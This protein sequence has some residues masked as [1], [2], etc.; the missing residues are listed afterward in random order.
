[1]FQFQ[2]LK[3]WDKL[4]ELITFFNNTFSNW[5]I[6]WGDLIHFNDYYRYE[7]EICVNNYFDVINFKGIIAGRKLSLIDNMFHV[8]KKILIFVMLKKLKFLFFF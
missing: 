1:M 4:L 2:N 6:T 3:S 5:K 8:L 7:F